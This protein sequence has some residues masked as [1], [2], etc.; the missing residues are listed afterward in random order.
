MQGVVTPN[1]LA[2]T[3]GRPSAAAGSGAASTI[4]ATAAAAL[5]RIRV[6]MR[7]SPAMSVTLGIRIR[8]VSRM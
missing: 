3:I 8:S 6:E 5:A 4:P 1:M 2:A 7:F